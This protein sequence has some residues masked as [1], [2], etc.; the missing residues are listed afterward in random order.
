MSADKHQALIDSGQLNEDGTRRQ[1]CPTC[2][3][4][5][6]PGETMPQPEGQSAVAFPDAVHVG[7]E[8]GEIVDE[9]SS[10]DVATLA[11]VDEGDQA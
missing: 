11:I 2:L 5:F 1:A 8:P 10:D 7:I 4:P 3:R 6:G 9:I